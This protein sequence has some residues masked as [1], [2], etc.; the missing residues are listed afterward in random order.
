MSADGSRPGG[1]ALSRIRPGP[2]L[3]QAIYQVAVTPENYDTLMEHWQAQLDAALAVLPPEA[4]SA[5]GGGDLIDLSEALPHLETSSRI[6]D[7]LGR[8]AHDGVSRHRS[9]RE[10]LHMLVDQAGRITWHN[11]RAGRLLMLRPGMPID[12]LPADA[13]TL[14]RLNAALRQCVEPEGAR[15]A[16]AFMLTLPEGQA[17]HMVAM[18]ANGPGGEGLLVLRSATARW[19]PLLGEMMREAFDLSNA[20]IDVVGLLVEGLDLP[21]IAAA[22]DRALNTVRTQLKTILRKTHTRTQAQVIRLSLSLAAHLPD[23]G[24]GERGRSDVAFL[25]LPSGRRMPWR[26]LGPHNGRPILFLH[27]MLDGIAI[28]D[29]A[30]DIL[31]RRKL[32]LIAPE[33]P[34]FGSAQ[35]APG[36]RARAVHRFA[37][38]LEALCAHLRLDNLVVMGHMAGAVYAFGLAARFPERVRTIVNVAGGVPI[39]S[40]RQFDLM[41]TRQRLVAFTARYA[42]QVL[43]FILRA[44]IRQIDAGG[45]R[46]FVSAL[47]QSSPLDLSALRQQDI[48]EIVTDGVRYA[49]E[50][51]HH[52]F[53]IDSYHVVRDWSGLVAA[54][55]CPVH[56]VHGRHDPVVAADTVEAFHETLG[57]RSSLHMIEDAGQLVYYSQPEAVFA[58]L[59]ELSEAG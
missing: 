49:V 23:T 37:G 14:D 16:H 25:N 36:P 26:R 30:H 1:P 38:D 59:D 44:G 48:F 41:S 3:L 39:L 40:P 22:R 24:E 46:R 7:Q 12:R 56:L 55:S 4:L 29:K 58:L 52:A 50:Q 8:T 28:T 15:T 11:A 42:P 35:G 27:G 17:L 47:F 53:E 19:S 20:E 10:G 45:E 32:Q 13:A 33:R 21:E 54:S 43:P 34:Y 51:G 6:L 5:A 18:P 31:R 9:L 57:A 2:E